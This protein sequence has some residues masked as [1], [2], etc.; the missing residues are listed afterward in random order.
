MTDNGACDVHPT[1]RR[2]CNDP[3]EHGDNVRDERIVREAYATLAEL[4]AR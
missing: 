2:G 1:C 3:R 4:A